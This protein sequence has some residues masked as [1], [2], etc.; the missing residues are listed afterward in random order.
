MTTRAPVTPE[1]FPETYKDAFTTLLSPIERK[2]VILKKVKIDPSQVL[3]LTTAFHFKKELESLDKTTEFLFKHIDRLNSVL[4][5]NAKLEI[6]GAAFLNEVGKILDE[7]SL[8][9]SV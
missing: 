8:D 1:Q 9:Y 6:N 5:S 2:L 3:A 7:E 4:Q